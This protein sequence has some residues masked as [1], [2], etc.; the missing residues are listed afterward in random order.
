MPGYQR[1]NDSLHVSK[2]VE[3]I[4]YTL[5]ATFKLTCDI[6]FVLVHAHPIPVPDVYDHCYDFE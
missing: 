1:M 2:H 3:V 6:K 5:F 4:L